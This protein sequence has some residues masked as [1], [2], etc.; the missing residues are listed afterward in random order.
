[1]TM[2]L[3][4]FVNDP[5]RMRDALEVA[6]LIKA[7]LHEVS[8]GPLAGDS[9]PLRLAFL[10]LGSGLADAINQSELDSTEALLVCACLEQARAPRS[11]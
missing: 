9:F 2:G 6:E 3:Q 11:V 8:Q 1:M 10:L 4:H 5:Q 7:R